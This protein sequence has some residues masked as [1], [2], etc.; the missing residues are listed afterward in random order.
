MRKSQLRSIKKILSKFK[1]KNVSTGIAVQE[2]NTAQSNLI[3][4]SDMWDLYDGDPNLMKFAKI[5]EKYEQE[6]AKDLFVNFKIPIQLR[7]H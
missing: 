6:K 3:T 5:Y 1:I 4:V 7:W 2:I